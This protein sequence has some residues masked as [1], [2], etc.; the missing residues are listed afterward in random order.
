MGSGNAWV[1]TPQILDQLL[2]QRK[3]EQLAAADRAEKIRQ[4]DVG[5]AERARA[6]TISERGQTLT[7]QLR[8]DQLAEAQRTHEAGIVQRMA[9]GQQPGAVTPEIATRLEMGGYGGQLQRTPGQQAEVGAGVLRTAPGAP[10]PQLFQPES[11]QSTGGR[12]YREARQQAAERA[13]QARETEATR[14][15]GRAAAQASTEQNRNIMQGIA[16]MNAQTQRMGAEE[17]VRASEE[18]RTGVEKEQAQRGAALT[19]QANETIRLANELEQHPGFSQVFGARIP[20]LTSIPGTN[21]AGANA[22]LEQLKSR[23][24]IDQIMQMKAQSRT[25]ATGFG[26][27]SD[28]EGAILTNAAGRLQQAQSEDEAKLALRDIRNTL[29]TVKARSGGTA[30][31]VP[32]SADELIRKYGGS[33]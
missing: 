1:Y 18:K 15:E 21:A 31:T 11:I 33:R 26:Q 16:G 7:E 14:A 10:T 13:A 19:D 27:L 4:F 6:H 9:E 28:R 20:Y 2:Q 12:L 25:G 32:L 5:T 30:T 24:T 22:R 17:R 29:N 8:R 23:L 3:L